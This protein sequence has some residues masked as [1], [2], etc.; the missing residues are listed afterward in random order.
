MKAKGEITYEEMEKVFPHIFRFPY[1]CNNSVSCKPCI[2]KLIAAGRQRND[3]VRG[4]R[5][6][7]TDKAGPLYGTVQPILKIGLSPKL[8]LPCIILHIGHIPCKNLNHIVLLRRQ[9]EDLRMC[10]IILLTLIGIQ[11]GKHGPVLHVVPIKNTVPV[12]KI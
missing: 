10:V 3:P 12:C 2:I 11:P 1:H 8:S 4:C 6:H 7:V 5:S 9:Q